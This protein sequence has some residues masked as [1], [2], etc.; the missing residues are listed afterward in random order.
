MS[1][2]AGILREPWPDVARQ[3]LGASFGIWAFLASE[4]LFFS[5]LFLSYAVYRSLHP[6]AFRI[7]AHET[8]ILYGTINTALLLTSSLNMTIA[9]RAA[10][11]GMRRLAITCLLITA[12][13]GA[14]FLTVKGL[15]Y[16]DDLAK[17]LF[18]GPSFPLRPASAQLFWGLYWVMTGV[19]AI[20]LTVGIGAVLILTGLIASEIIPLQTTAAEVTSL[21]W[22]LVDV[23]WVVLYALLYLGGRT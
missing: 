9:G 10:T 4:V 18:P 7:A 21:Y 16:S 17:G 12:A 8:N 15:E 6:D 22:H 20:H 2:A 5:A 3:R 23:I 1:D 11:E 19:H 14:A 13:F